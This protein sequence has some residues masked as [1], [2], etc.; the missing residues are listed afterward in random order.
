M[1]WGRPIWVELIYQPA[2]KVSR[3]LFRLF[4]GFDLVD[5]LRLVVK[6]FALLVVAGR[7]PYHFPTNAQSERKKD[8][9]QID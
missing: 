2:T 1:L 3:N 8:H 5:V 9:P 7:Y 6:L 4:T